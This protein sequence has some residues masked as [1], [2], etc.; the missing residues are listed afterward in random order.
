MICSNCGTVNEAGRKFC[1][2]CAAR[3]VATCPAC[4]AANAPTAKFCGECATP[5]AAP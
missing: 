4:G 1:S 2:E 5:L 3:L